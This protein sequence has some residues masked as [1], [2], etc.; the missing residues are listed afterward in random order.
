MKKLLLLLLL[1][2]P[3]VF[4]SCAKCV[5]SHSEIGLMHSTY[6]AVYGRKGRCYYY[7]VATIPYTYNVCDKWINEE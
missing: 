1:F 6:C 4:T 3:F 5:S 7:E 2:L